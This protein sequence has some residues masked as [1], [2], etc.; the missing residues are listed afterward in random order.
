MNRYQPGAS[1]AGSWTVLTERLG[2][3]K[4]RP[5]PTTS[6]ALGSAVVTAVNILTTLAMLLHSFAGCCWHHG[7]A[8]C[9]RT[10]DQEAT[11]ADHDCDSHEHSGPEASED[12]SH[13]ASEAIVGTDPSVTHEQSPPCNEG[14]CVFV[15]TKPSSLAG[16]PSMI[17]GVLTVDSQAAVSVWP[18]AISP[19]VRSC[20]TS[21]S[22]LAF[23][24]RIRVWLL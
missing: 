14:H 20:P 15:K 11:A 18:A 9:C 7:H 6:D 8:D 2:S 13:H 21:T 24:A 22:A 5:Q 12:C 3:A 19:T 10:H 16:P 17:V 4:I 23:C 1:V